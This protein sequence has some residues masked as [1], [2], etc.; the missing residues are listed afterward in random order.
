MSYWL[1]FSFSLFS[2]C[3]EDM[4][5]RKIDSGSELNPKNIEKKIEK[6][7]MKLNEAKRKKCV[8]FY[9]IMLLD[10]KS[11]KLNSGTVLFFDVPALKCNMLQFILQRSKRE[12]DRRMEENEKGVKKKQKRYQS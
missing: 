12:Q 10:L 1:L 7:K 2:F 5:Q 4:L 11:N 6:Q 9:T 8:F 3:R